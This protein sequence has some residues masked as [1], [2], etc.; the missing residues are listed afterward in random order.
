MRFDPLFFR[1]RGFWKNLL[2]LVLPIALQNLISSSLNL[3]DNL[4]VGQLGETALGALSLANQISFLLILFTF[5][6]TSGAA[7]FSAQ[8]WGAR[9]LAGVRRIQGL[10]LTLSVS[11][12]TLFTLAAQ[13]GAE[14]IM[15]LYTPDSEIRRL[16]AEYLR[17]SS[18]A[19][20]LTALS[21]SFALV[22]RS[23]GEVRFPLVLSVGALVINVTLNYG[24]I[25]G[26]L[27]LPA[28]GVAG[29]ALGT[30]VARLFESVGLVILSYFHRMPNAGR[31]SELFHWPRGFLGPYIK[32][33]LPVLGQELGWALGITTLMGIYAHM[34]NQA[35]AAMTITDTLNQFLNILIF[36]SV[37][38]AAVMTGNTVGAGRLG[39][40]RVLARR[41]S[42]YSPVLGAT[43]GLIMIVFSSLLPTLFQ[44]SA[45]SRELAA[46]LLVILGFY[47]AFRSFVFHLSVGIFRG[48]GDTRTAMVLELGGVWV[49]GIPLA[50]L[51]SVVL[52]LDFPLV[53]LL[54]ESHMFLQT[55]VAY[56]RLR[57]GKWIKPVAH[58]GLTK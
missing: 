9:D 35:L 34:G 22:L 20:P 29:A 31:L 49:M 11:A 33:S 41:F 16:G 39:R 37:S 4:M 5:G 56:R 48:A 36:G 28:L 52:R 18:W 43:V 47:Q 57:S 24:L 44:V 50:W 13:T 53:Y 58:T 7:V 30:L 27:G 23:V 32:T 10:A 54:A 19:F 55:L 3:T 2:T 14:G 8:F 51:G 40:A 38:A 17:I 1:D 26:N 46:T 25:F 15:G 45:Q 21:M 12:A 42:R 6:I